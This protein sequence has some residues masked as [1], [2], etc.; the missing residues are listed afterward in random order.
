V[1]ADQC[2]RCKK[3]GH[4]A[5]EC[6]T[7]PKNQAA[8]LAQWENEEVTLLM[9]RVSSIQISPSP[10]AAQV[11]S[12]PATVPMV[13]ERPEDGSPVELVEEK[14]F[15]QF[16]GGSSDDGGLWH[17]D[18]GATNHMSGSRAIFFEL[19]RGIVGTVRFGDGSV[20]KIKGRGTVVFS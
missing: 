2:Y 9:T 8:H 1:A 16:D 12:A 4:W 3:T 10:T 5:R 20:V 14:V 18:K 15:A 19:D 7:K 6:P 17:L 13:A 11:N